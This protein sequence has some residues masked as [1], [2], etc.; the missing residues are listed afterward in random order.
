MYL[1]GFRNY[2]FE[3]RFCSWLQNLPEGPTKAPKRALSGLTLTKMLCILR[4]PKANF[5]I[6]KFG[7]NIKAHALYN[8]GG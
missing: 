4:Q 6:A 8:W 1:S 5:A 2:A 7:L 3:P